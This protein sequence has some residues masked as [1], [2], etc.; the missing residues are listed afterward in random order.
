MK[1]G[2]P[3]GRCKSCNE[4]LPPYP[5]RGPVREF[6][7]K[8]RCNKNGR[9]RLIKIS[10]GYYSKGWSKHGSSGSRNMVGGKE[11][12]YCQG[13]GNEIPGDLPSFFFRMRNEYYKICG[14]CYFKV[15]NRDISR[16]KNLLILLRNL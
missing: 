6:C 14:V 1:K 13:C 8:G 12:W 15:R 7:A 5:G 16:F 2:D 9:F 3:Q 4:E 11:N 10:K